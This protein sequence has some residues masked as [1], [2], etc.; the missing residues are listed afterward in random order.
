MGGGAC[1]ITEYCAPSALENTLPNAL[2]RGRKYQYGAGSGRL[3]TSR[4]I[5]T[6]SRKVPPTCAP[7]LTGASPVPC[8][9]LLTDHSRTGLWSVAAAAGA[10]TTSE[11]ESA[12]AM[13]DTRM[14]G[15]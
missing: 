10:A 6:V 15:R 11:R 4:P 13:K 7:C 3:K 9:T 2:S 1:A 14:R 8:T 5:S 12:T